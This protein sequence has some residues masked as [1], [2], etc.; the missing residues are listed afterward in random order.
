MLPLQRDCW[1]EEVN[2]SLSC[3]ECGEKV[4]S[5]LGETGRNGYT[6]GLEHLDHLDAR[7][8]DKSGLCLHSIYHHNSRQDVTYSMR[9]TGGFSDCLDRQTMEM[10]RINNFQGQV[11]MNRRTEMGGVRVERTQYRRWG[12]NQ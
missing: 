10:V 5:Y 8:E 12:A 6:R 1:K 4:V 9:I 2:Y 3:N 11:L 7:N